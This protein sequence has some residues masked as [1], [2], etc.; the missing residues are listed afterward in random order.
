MDFR[1]PSMMPSAAPSFTVLDD[2]SSTTATTTYPKVQTSPKDSPSPLK[3][4]GGF[5][6]K[7]FLQDFHDNS[8]PVSPPTEKPMGPKVWQQIGSPHASRTENVGF[9]TSV[10]MSGSFAA[11]GAPRSNDGQGYVQTFQKT[12]GEWQVLTNI[13][14]PSPGALGQALHMSSGSQRTVLVVGAPETLG[15]ADL[16]VPFGSVHY[17][18]LVANRK[19]CTHPLIN[20][21]LSRC[22]NSCNKNK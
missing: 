10:T 14:Y 8:A 9:G 2:S 11:V 16:A 22:A 13:L 6:K 5:Q 4:G 21:D 7:D 17:L 18:E 19:E 1:D 20:L 12:D 3:G 15:G